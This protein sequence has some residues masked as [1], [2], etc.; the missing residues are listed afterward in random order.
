MTHRLFLSKLVEAVWYRWRF[1]LLILMPQMIP[2]YASEGYTLSEWGMVNTFILTHPFKDFFAGFYPVFQIMPLVLLVTIFLAG[3][4]VSRIFSGYAAVTYVIIAFLQ[5]ISVSDTY[6]FAVHTANLMTFLTLAGLW[7]RETAFPQNKF[8]IQKNT[9]WKYWAIPL[10]L[11]AFWFPVNPILLTPD[12]DPIY[13]LTSGSGLSFCMV[14]P[15]YLAI[16]APNFPQINKPVFISTGVIGV[17]MGLGNMLLEFIIYPAFWWIGIFHIPLLIISLWCVVLSF[18][19][20]A[21]QVREAVIDM[22][23]RASA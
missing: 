20:I 13:L 18:N 22:G 11:L 5:S 19:E 17:M 9:I 21:G 16:L 1:L 10:A 3:R 23:V 15:L 6:G 7:F 4:R 2:P 12:F 8:K 14:T